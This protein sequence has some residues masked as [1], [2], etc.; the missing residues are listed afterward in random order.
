MVEYDSTAAAVRQQALVGRRSSGVLLLAD[1]SGYTDLLTSA[2][3]EFSAKIVHHITDRVFRGT[4]PAFIVN[5][6]EGDALFVYAPG[7]EGAAL[8]RATL[9]QLEA[10]ADAFYH[11]MEELKAAETSESQVLER[12]SM[13]FIVHFGEF[14]VNEIGPFV[15]LVGSDVILAHRLLKN[16]V[17]SDSYFLFTRSFLA[18]N[19][20]P[21]QAKTKPL[22]EQVKYF[23]NVEV[24]VRTFDYQAEHEQRHGSS[25]DHLTRRGGSIT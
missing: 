4:T 8:Y 15:K 14:V 2:Q 22:F 24:G 18:L 13:K 25:H 19:P 1:I 12:I 17:S 5:E 6:I 23:G 3:A 10:Y 16:S 11:A 7:E 20:E 9:Q 21:E